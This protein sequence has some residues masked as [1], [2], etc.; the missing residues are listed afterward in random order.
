MSIMDSFFSE[1]LKRRRELLGE[2]NQISAEFIIR[3]IKTHPEPFGADPDFDQKAIR[4]AEDFRDNFSKESCE[5]VQHEVGVWFASHRLP[6]GGVDE[7]SKHREAAK[8]AI[9]KETNV[10]WI[11]ALGALTV[12]GIVVFLLTQTS[13]VRDGC[14]ALRATPTMTSTPTATL[15]QTA[16]ST[17][18]ARATSTALTTPTAIATPAAPRDAPTL[19]Q[20][21]T[22]AQWP[23]EIR[24]QWNLERFGPF[25]LYPG[26]RVGFYRHQCRSDH[27]STAACNLDPQG[28]VVVEL[29][30]CMGK[31]LRGPPNAKTC[32]FVK[33]DDFVDTAVCCFNQ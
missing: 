20:Q 11:G 16:T 7:F 15:T 27:V 31:V 10:R 24:S 5:K 17:P 13:L 9:R 29:T 2:F 4:W 1:N 23:A 30:N 33:D 21:P 22:P 3:A 19:P 18:T 28:R 25:H 8:R 26:E 12:L 14:A 32:S 6:P